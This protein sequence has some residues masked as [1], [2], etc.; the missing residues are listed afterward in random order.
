MEQ[1]PS[2]EANSFSASQ[3]VLR[4]LW[5]LKVH[6]LIHKSPPPV[7]ILSHKNS[8]HL[9]YWRSNLTSSHL[10]L[11]LQGGLFPWGFPT[12]TLYGTLLFP[13]RTA[14]PS[15]FITWIIFTEQYRSLSSSLYSFLHSPV[16]SSRLGPNI[17]LSTPFAN[18]LILS[19]SLNV[20]DQVSHQYKTTGKIMILC[21]MF[22]VLYMFG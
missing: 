17:I 19:S 15:H 12:K 20:R 9:T 4:I 6:Y 2:R 22:Y 10:G 5:N 1:N 16:T 13:I 7:P 14:C 3:E 11:G 18:T 21:S 8:D